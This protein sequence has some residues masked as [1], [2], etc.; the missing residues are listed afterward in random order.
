MFDNQS[1]WFMLICAARGSVLCVV[2]RQPVRAQAGLVSSDTRRTAWH[3]SAAAK[4][5]DH[6]F[7]RRVEA[8]L[9]KARG[10]GDCAHRFIAEAGDEPR[11]G[12]LAFYLF[13]YLVPMDL[14]YDSSYLR[15]GSGSL[16]VRNRSASGGVWLD[17]GPCAGFRL[18]LALLDWQG[19]PMRPSDCRARVPGGEGAMNPSRTGFISG[20]SSHPAGQRPLDVLTAFAA[21]CIMGVS[22]PCLSL[23]GHPDSP[24]PGRCACGLHP[25]VTS[26]LRGDDLFRAL[27]VFAGDPVRGVAVRSASA[28]GLTLFSAPGDAGI[29]AYYAQWRSCVDSR[30]V[31]ETDR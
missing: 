6:Q 13:A 24:G 20:S 28:S 4:E 17:V 9:W 8:M 26:V 27:G 7:Q 14:I 25:L 22:V 18:P 12:G 21:G 31:P 19:C 10:A 16:R 23:S 30:L 3:S 5:Y 11:R 29:S 1:C 15:F 2:I